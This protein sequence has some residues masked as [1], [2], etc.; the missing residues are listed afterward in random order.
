MAD[1]SVPAI[2]YIER[3]PVRAKLVRTVQSWRWGSGY[4]RQRGTEKERLLL[5]DPPVDLPRNY[6]QWVNTPDKEEDLVIIR[7]SVNKSK[8]FGTMGWT[9]RMVEKFGLGATLRG[10][11]RP[12]TTRNGT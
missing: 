2:K 5:S 11:G 4:R 12:K 8:P 1:D 3:N 6:W 10:P 7:N 9:E